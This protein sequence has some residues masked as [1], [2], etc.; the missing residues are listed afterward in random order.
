LN[1]SDDQSLNEDKEGG[2]NEKYININ[3]G[4]AY[5]RVSNIEDNNI[6]NN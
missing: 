6:R 2:F 5:K 3:K 4:S 1:Q